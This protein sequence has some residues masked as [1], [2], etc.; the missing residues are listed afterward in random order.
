[1]AMWLRKK[2]NTATSANV[3]MNVTVTD[4][5]GT[6]NPHAGSWRTEPSARIAVGRTSRRTCRASAACRGSRMKLPQI[7]RP[8]LRRGQRQR[9]DR[10]GE[11]DPDHGDDRRRDRGQHDSSRIGAA[12][13]APTTET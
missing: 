9:D 12:A 7:P 13:E 3:S 1:M 4:R 6:N 2:I 11:H 10:D 5:C 8:E